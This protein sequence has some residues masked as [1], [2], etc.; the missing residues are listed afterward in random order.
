MAMWSGHTPGLN[1]GYGVWYSTGMHLVNE[2]SIHPLEGGITLVS[3]LRVST[4]T[5]NLPE[6][7]AGGV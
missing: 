7:E 6:H 2:G 5:A 3:D 4:K 1:V